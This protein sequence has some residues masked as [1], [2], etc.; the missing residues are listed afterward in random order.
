MK[1]ISLN[2]KDVG[3]NEVDVDLAIA[4][5]NHLWC[6]TEWRRDNSWRIIAYLRKDSPITKLKLTI[7]SEQA[8]ELIQKLNLVGV[9]SGFASGFTYR[10][11]KDWD[12]L[13]DYRREK[14]SKKH[15]L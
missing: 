6:L 13:E 14:F 9:N 3:I 10:T 7:S 1:N 15:S 4:Q 8:Q 5:W 2:F 11:E 12:S